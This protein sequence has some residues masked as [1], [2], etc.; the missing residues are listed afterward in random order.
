MKRILF[1]AVT[2]AAFAVPAQAADVGVS[3][4]VGQPG[5]YGQIDIGSFSQPPVLYRQPK[6]VEV[7]QVSRPPIYMRVPPG[8]ARD[9][10]KHCREYNACGERVYFVQDSWYSQ[11]YVPRYQKEHG[12]K[13]G[14]KKDDRK[15]DGHGQGRDH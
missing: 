5:F 2:A 1:A 15:G 6:V 12:G 11:E 10:K 7:L 3:V 13:H 9:W 14:K 8:H 4:S